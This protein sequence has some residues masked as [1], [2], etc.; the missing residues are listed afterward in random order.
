MKRINALLVIACMALAATGCKGAGDSPAAVEDSTAK[1]ESQNT[2]VVVQQTSGIRPEV[3][4][5]KEYVFEEAYEDGVYAEPYL[6]G[7][8]D[9]FELAPEAKDAYPALA[10]TF[11]SVMDA[12]NKKYDELH[13]QY[14]EDSKRIRDDYGAPTF[15]LESELF[16]RRADDK[17]ISFVDQFTEYSAGAH[18]HT[19]YESYNFDV[20]AGKELALADVVTDKDAFLSDISK[21]LVEK[22]GAD[23]FNDLDKRLGEI[24]LSDYHWAF[25]YSGITL[26]FANDIAAYAAGV[27]TATIPYDSNCLNRDYVLAANEGIISKIPLYFPEDKHIDVVNGCDGGISITP[28]YDPNNPDLFYVESLT[29]SKDGESYTT[30]TLY[31][32]DVDAYILHNADGSEYLMIM[33]T[34]DSDYNCSYVFSLDGKIQQVSNDY[35]D[36]G[37]AGT[38]E[39]YYEVVPSDPASVAFAS[40]FDM[41]CT[42]DGTRYYSF[43]SNGTFTPYEKFYKAMISKQCDLISKVELTVPVVD[44]AG[45]ETGE[46]VTLPSGTHYSIIRTNGENE[47]DCTIS[48]GRIIRF[49]LESPN[50]D[51]YIGDYEINGVNAYDLFE[52]LWYAG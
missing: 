5:S 38:T 51:G 6:T 32:W 14:L 43:E 12:R 25:D 36:L 35:F 15:N 21:K 16:L 4:S 24:K 29:I 42:F 2:E 46:E 52:M 50:K 49:H 9:K 40:R 37:D 23:T 19:S 48:D 3:Y 39:E 33:T 27:M 26:Y 1:E 41:L 47:V 13:K 17:V 31:V 18:G 44:E 20:Q 7:H 28:N 45:E 34:G 11:E 22:Y 30:D 8:Y 10:E